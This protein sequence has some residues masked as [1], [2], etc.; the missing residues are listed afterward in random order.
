MF[1]EKPQHTVDLGASGHRNVELSDF[2]K[3]MAMRF[4]FFL[5][6]Q[7]RRPPRAAGPLPATVRVASRAMF[8]EKSGLVT[9]I[10]FYVRHLR[11]PVSKHD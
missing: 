3:R 2:S 9:P 1:D 4:R 6:T 7:A 5:T 11:I 8:R 10:I